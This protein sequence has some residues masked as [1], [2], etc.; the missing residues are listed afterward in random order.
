MAAPSSNF[1]RDF[2]RRLEAAKPGEGQGCLRRCEGT[3]SHL[4]LRA[5]RAPEKRPADRSRSRHR[6]A[7][8]RSQPRPSAHGPTVGRPVTVFTQACLDSLFKIYTDLGDRGL[9][10]EPAAPGEAELRKAF[11]TA[12]P[13]KLTV[14]HLRATLRAWDEW[15]LHAAAS[16]LPLY[17]PTAMQV[18]IFLQGAAARGATVAPA[19]LR[20]FRW[21]RE[22]LGLPFPVASSMLMGFS[23]A[24]PTHIP[25][26]ARTFSPDE[27]W[28]I[29]GLSLAE[30]ERRG[31]EAAMTIFASLACI[32]CAHLG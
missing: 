13:A 22:H 25:K 4:A 21:L 16:G 18:G 28:S 23:H 17:Q 24:P 27:F 2:L 12:V 9:A 30:G 5:L 6:V 29:V 11:V 10:W 26:Q 14:P 1:R 19:R 8:A 7:R 15:S 3:P 32:R 20:A 31:V